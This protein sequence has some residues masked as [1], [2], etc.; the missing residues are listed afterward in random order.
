MFKAT[1]GVT[2]LLASI[3][4]MSLV[5]AQSLLLQGKRSPKASRLVRFPIIFPGFPKNRITVYTRPDKE[6]NK[7]NSLCRLG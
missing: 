4:A 3:V 2:L 1:V 7:R 5:F 6:P